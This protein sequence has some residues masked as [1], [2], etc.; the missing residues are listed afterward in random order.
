MQGS[1]METNLVTQMLSEG[2][3]TR[4]QTFAAIAGRNVSESGGG[5][6]NGW[7][8]CKWV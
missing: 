3:E 4:V 5:G 1:A 8:Y 2:L 6:T 7:A